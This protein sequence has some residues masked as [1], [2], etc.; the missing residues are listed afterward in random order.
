MSARSRTARH[1]G[2]DALLAFALGSSAAAQA[3]LLGGGGAGA[4]VSALAIAAPFLAARRRTD[5]RTFLAIASLGGL[6]MLLGAR[7]DVALLGRPE[8]VH[9]APALSSL[10]SLSTAAML[11]VCFGWQ[12]LTN[13]P[14]C[15]RGPAARL[16]VCAGMLAGMWAGG[17]LVASHGPSM[18][19]AMV[20]GMA[21]GHVASGRLVGHLSRT[22]AVR[23]AAHEVN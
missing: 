7:L 2:R 10:L 19:V 17:A 6:A 5:A 9:G 3:L 12:A 1:V 20:L 16:F 18:H 8:H 14:H 22:A 13:D 21:L 11:V 15:P 4:A 23:D